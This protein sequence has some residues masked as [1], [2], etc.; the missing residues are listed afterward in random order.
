MS[1]DIKYILTELEVR[2]RN[3][4]ESTRESNIRLNI[5]DS[6]IQSLFSEFK[7][8]AISSFAGFVVGCITLKIIIGN[9]N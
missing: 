8:V 5:Y 1:E 3:A 9:S 6:K 7:I 4:E 2:L